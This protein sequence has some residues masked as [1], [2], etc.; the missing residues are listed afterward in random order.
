MK[1]VDLNQ[2][3]E[4]PWGLV[5]IKHELEYDP[6]K[7]RTKTIE[8][9][10]K[11]YIRRGQSFLLKTSILTEN[12][13]WFVD[14]LWVYESTNNDFK[15]DKTVGYI[16]NCLHFLKGPNPIWVESKKRPYKRRNVKRGSL[17]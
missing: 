12:D 2:G 7:K 9:K 15:F 13:Y 8:R 10:I 3:R 1:Y 17:L 14:G 5:R 16:T 6:K 11:S 4:D